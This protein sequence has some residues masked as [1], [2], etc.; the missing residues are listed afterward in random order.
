MQPDLRSDE[1]KAVDAAIAGAVARERER[2]ARIAL[3]FDSGR[4][5]EKE[6][7]RAIRNPI[8]VSSSA[9]GKTP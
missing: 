6:I 8:T 4:G 7:A 5:N 3:A 1:M 9:T 2:C